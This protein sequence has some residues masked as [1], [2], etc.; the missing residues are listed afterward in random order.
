MIRNFGLAIRAFLKALFDPAFAGRIRGLLEAPSPPGP[1]VEVEEKATP[2]PPV[3]SEA[4]DLLAALQR[5]ARL[6][7]FL[8]EPIQGYG[9]AQIGAAVRDVHANASAV[10]KRFFDLN[11]V[12]SENENSPLE[13]P[14]GFEAFE[15]HLT[16]NVSGSPPFHGVLRHHGW[17]AAK[18]ELPTWNGPSHLAGIIAPAEVE[19][20]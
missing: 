14:E 12:R 1:E 13:V 6:V 19:I 4:L 20:R 15:F 8:M 7:D 11:P 18:C 2:A 5:E 10:L 16:G 17:R 3:R 9:D